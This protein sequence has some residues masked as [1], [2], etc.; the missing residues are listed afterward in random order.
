M[1]K[2]LNI[3]IFCFVK[4]L[5]HWKVK[6][7][8]KSVFS[9][10]Q[11]QHRIQL[12]SFVHFCWCWVRASGNNEQKPFAMRGFL[13]GLCQ[14]HIIWFFSIE[15]DLP[16]TSDSMHSNLKWIKGKVLQNTNSFTSIKNLIFFYF[17]M[18]HK[19]TQAIDALYLYIRISRD[20]FYFIFWIWLWFIIKLHAHC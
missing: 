18:W 4:F 17:K 11:S 5:Q 12:W 7:I 10:F 15:S 13:R 20:L 2:S 1:E 8:W 9:I 3:S 14:H 16:A 6:P 19:H